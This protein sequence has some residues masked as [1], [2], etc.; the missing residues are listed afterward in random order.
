MVQTNSSSKRIDTFWSIYSL[1][2]LS[3]S[4]LLWQIGRDYFIPLW[5]V[6]FGLLFTFRQLISNKLFNILKVFITLG[7]LFYLLKIMTEVWGIWQ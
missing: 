6:L 2:S 3:F 1:V 4:I 5:M 7:M